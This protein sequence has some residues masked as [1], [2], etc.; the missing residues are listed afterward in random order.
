MQILR[1]NY[2]KTLTRQ[3]FGETLKINCKEPHEAA[4][5]RIVIAMPGERNE[6]NVLR[7]SSL[8]LLWK[9][10]V[11]QS[12]KWELTEHYNHQYRHSSLPIAR[13]ELGITGTSSRPGRTLWPTGESRVSP[14][15]S[16]GLDSH[17]Y[18]TH[19]Q[20]QTGHTAY[21]ILLRNNDQTLSSDTFSK[22]GLS[23]MDSQ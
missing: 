1:S 20:K 4:L 15:V 14:R 17:S 19:H 10:E 3:V 9:T 7:M 12:M 21:L 16:G 5:C 23:E 2:A 22:S 18:T 11:P 13:E 8:T 6:R